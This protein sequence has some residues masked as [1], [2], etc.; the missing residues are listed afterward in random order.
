MS[1]PRRAALVA[2]ILSVLPLAACADDPPP[3]AAR[4]ATSAATA[5]A[6][7]SASTPTPS[8]PT[9]TLRSEL[10]PEEVANHPEARLGLARVERTADGLRVITSWSLDGAKARGAIATSEDGFATATY[11]EW[12]DR[13]ATVAFPEVAEPR[14]GPPND[15]FSLL[16]PVPSLDPGVSEGVSAYVMGGDGS[17]YLSFE[18]VARSTDA[19]E[20]WDLFDV[21]PVDDALPYIARAVA[22]EDG[23]LLAL[24]PGWSNDTR[25][26]GPNHHGLWVS[27]GD[28]WGSYAP[29]EP[30]YSPALSPQPKGFASVESLGGSRTNAGGVVWSTTWDGKLY[31]STDD[32]ATFSE[33]AVR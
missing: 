21:P 15:D 17:T 26:P 19:G 16:Q 25:R 9:T 2:A 5:S 24:V 14:Q 7:A 6:S 11:E 13:T 30:T 31:A 23:R 10:S 8:G 32:G 28:D 33:V 4:D 18:R 27:D 12:N 1:T 22:L 20:S 3:V 29:V